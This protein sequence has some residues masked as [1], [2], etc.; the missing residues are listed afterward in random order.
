MTWIKRGSIFNGIDAQL[1]VVDIYPTKYRIYFSRRLKGCSLPVW[2]DINKK[3][4][5]IIKTQIDKPILELGKIGSFDHYGVMPT[6]IVT[7][8]DGTK[9]LYYVGWSKRLDV[10]YHNSTGLAISKD[11]GKTWKKY[12]EGPIFNTSAKEPGFIGTISI[13][14]T[15]EDKYTH[16]V[17]YYS[18]A[19]WEEIN[20][21]LEPVYDIKSATSKDGINW[22]CTEITNL[23]LFNEE[24]GI[25]SFRKFKDYFFFSVRNKFDYRTNLNNSYRIKST[26]SNMEYETLE[27]SP[28]GDENMCAYPFLVDEEDRII[29]FYNTD[30]GSKGISYAIKMNRKIQKNNL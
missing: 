5:S 21:K 11:N 12:S 7:L 30:F 2:V 22:E 28:E 20:G 1:P 26:N 3:D 4:F 16:W 18:S 15:N 23:K 24:G 8:K 10:P 25:A 9:Y 14:H 13:S 19:H 29:M 27:L 6:D 17:M